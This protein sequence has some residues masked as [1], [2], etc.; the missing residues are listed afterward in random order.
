MGKLGWD[1]EQDLGKGP[2]MGP[3]P[4][5]S[6]LHMPAAATLGRKD[7]GEGCRDAPHHPSGKH[8]PQLCLGWTQGPAGAPSSCRLCTG[9]WGQTLWSLCDQLGHK[10]VPV[11]LLAR[12]HCTEGNLDLQTPSAGCPGPPTALPTNNPRPRR[13]YCANWPRSRTKLLTRLGGRTGGLAGGPAGR[14]PGSGRAADG[15]KCWGASPRPP[16]SGLTPAQGWALPNRPGLGGPSGA[17][18]PTAEA[19]FPLPAPS[20]RTGAAAQTP[21][22]EKRLR[23][24]MEKAT[25]SWQVESR[26][27]RGHSAPVRGAEGHLG[28]PTS[29]GCPA[30]LPPLG[31]STS[32][33]GET[34]AERPQPRA[35]PLALPG[36]EP[37]PPAAA[38]MTPA[39]HPPPA[40]PCSCRN[41][42]VRTPGRQPGPPSCCTSRPAC[43]GS[44]AGS[45]PGSRVPARPAGAS[46][47]SEEKSE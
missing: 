39:P 18:P 8:R 23:K 26:R 27:G 20:V 25:L 1:L 6:C 4:P 11:T 5:R 35:E 32:L 24:E 10:D 38:G 33:S 15:P 34:E 40:P 46:C 3:L 37:L 22:G 45:G 44:A 14:G 36:R 30:A 7:A 41:P 19:A 43:P 13:D 29:L 42:G 47:P 21:A 31:C 17:S 9:G 16:G 12:A 2:R 28:V